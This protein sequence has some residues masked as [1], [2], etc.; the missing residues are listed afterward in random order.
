VTLHDDR[1]AGWSASCSA[2]SPASPTS[3]SSA[4]GIERSASHREAR[5][6]DERRMAIKLIHDGM[7]DPRHEPP[8]N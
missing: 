5:L 7:N 4:S 8:A 2:I 1:M 3:R 6:E